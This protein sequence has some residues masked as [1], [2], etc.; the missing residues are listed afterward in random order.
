[1][2]TTMYQKKLR[3]FFY[4]LY[5]Y[6]IS[7]IFFPSSDNYGDAEDY[8]FKRL[9]PQALSMLVVIISSTSFFSALTSRISAI[10][11]FYWFALCTLLNF[12]IT[13]V[14]HGATLYYVA[15]QC[16]IL[17]WILPIYYLYN[18]FCHNDG[19]VIHKYLTIYIY[20]FYA[21]LIIAIFQEYAFRASETIE[22]LTVGQGVYSGGA[23]YF[24]VPLIFAV[25]DKRRATYL[26]LIG[27][28]IAVLTAKRAPIIL[29]LVFG[30]F[31][32][33]GMIR[34]LKAKDYAIIGILA[35]IAITYLL[36]E[37][38]DMMMERNEL[39]AERG[40]SYGS[41]REIFYAIVFNSWVNSGLTEQLFGHGF[42]SVQALLLREYGM[43]I[44]SHNGFLDCVYVYGLVG[45]I[46]YVSI[47]ICLITRYKTVKRLL[48]EMK[49]VYGAFIC[50]WFVQNLI[51]H[52]FARP[53]MI[54]YGIF[55][56]YTEYKIFRVQKYG[57]Q[58]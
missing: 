31:Q 57:Y 58:C 6:L 17:V 43:A 30:L 11:V 7:S 13:L 24:L 33:K 41:G 8:G 53:N 38:W 48:P 14:N 51:I 10:K 44:S 54:P 47:F 4:I 26:W 1:M 34:S 50:M 42:G 23:I 25:F 5:A 9:I 49:S 52:G 37:Y 19:N 40:G 3:I 35:T 45:L 56:A 20:I 16:K 32:L 29:L 36:A 21:Y 2:N 22:I 46:F 27:M 28:G 39:D 55:L 15:E 18:V 12:A